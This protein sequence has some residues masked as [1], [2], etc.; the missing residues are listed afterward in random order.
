MDHAMWIET[1]LLSYVVQCFHHMNLLHCFAIFL[2]NEYG[3]PYIAFYERLL[4]YLDEHPDTISGRVFADI[5]RRLRAVIDGT[6]GLLCYADEF[7]D[8]SWPF[9]E[10]AFLK[11]IYELDTFYEEIRA[12]LCGFDLPEDLFNDLL[13]YQ[14][15]ILKRPLGKDCAF[16]LDYALHEYFSRMLSG[17]SIRP[18]KRPNIV[19]I[20]DSG[21]DFQF[22]KSTPAALSVRAKK[23]KMSIPMPSRLRMHSMSKKNVYL[24]Q[25]GFAFDKSLYVPYAVGAL[26]A[27]ALRD[28]VI[29]SDY[30]FRDFIFRREP[31]DEVLAPL[32]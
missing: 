28:E 29:R 32:Y 2:R 23:A 15:N 16:R 4:A 13:L 10:Y 6:G 11:I 24:V 31:L 14:Q 26:A 18:E 25:V 9:E 3:L 27:Y 20:R 5:R 12:F 30:V 8:V 1:N 7:G 17:V 19:T 21:S 22:G